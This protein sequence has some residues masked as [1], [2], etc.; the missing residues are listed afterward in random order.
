MLS[1]TLRSPRS[2]VFTQQQRGTLFSS[3]WR[4]ASVS[5]RH[6]PGTP[7]LPKANQ[8]AHQQQHLHHRSAR[9]SGLRKAAR[10]AWRQRCVREAKKSTRPRAAPAAA[11]TSQSAKH[12]SSLHLAKSRQ[13][14]LQRA[15]VRQQLRHR[16]WRECW[17]QRQHLRDVAGSQA[18]GCCQHTP[19]DQRRSSKAST[20]CGPRVGSG[21]AQHHGL[22]QVSGVGCCGVVCACV[23]KQQ[24]RCC[25][26]CVCMSRAKT[27]QRADRL[28]KAMT[29]VVSR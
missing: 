5:L 17:E 19:A 6:N 12:R 8:T 22:L 18:Q 21:R 7:P 2:V 11:V 26:V 28:S 16:P 29:V 13:Q 9:Q 20:T 25:V 27:V 23:R 14:A 15:R 10:T 3:V 4:A 1:S 24:P